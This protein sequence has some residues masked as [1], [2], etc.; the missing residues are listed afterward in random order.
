L[1]VNEQGN[2]ME[3]FLKTISI[4]CGIGVVLL[5]L[6]FFA[7]FGLFLLLLLAALYAWALF[8]FL[9]YRQCR[10]EE[11]LQVITVAAE[12]RSPLSLAL[13]AAL[14]DRPRG[15]LREFWVAALLFFVLPGYYW[16]WYRR[17]NFDSKIDQVAW[18]LE[19]GHSLHDAL[20]MTPG[21]AT[22]STMLAVRLGQETGELALCLQAFRTP[23]RSRL[24]T[25]WIE[26]VPR[27]AYPFFLLLVIAGVLGFWTIMVAPK[28]EKIFH[29]FSFSMPEETQRAIALGR[30]MLGYWWVVVLG[31]LLFGVVMVLLVAN[32]GFRWYFPVIGHLYRRYVRS[33]ILQALS[34]LLQMNRPAPAALGV[35]AASDCFVAGAQRRLRAIH[36]QVELGQPLADSLRYGGVL[37][38]AMVPLL[39]TAEKAG[40]LPWALAE[41]ADTLSQRVARRAQRLGMAVSP[42][43]LLGVGVIMA[44][45]VVGFFVPL[46]AIMEGLAR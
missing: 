40:N 45:I 12:A 37:P 9:H 5:V 22:R 31:A 33:Q 10:Q 20:E 36:R 4:L 14:A 1:D 27:F 41:M 6:F 34:F 24:A 23:V 17:S 11:F 43:P 13:R 29:E 21:V 2:A 28:Y 32:P 3:R 35:L 8:A 44:M 15:T 16:L 26:M 7:G 19:E 46:I 18:L 30:N 42:I 39:R 25:L 38:R